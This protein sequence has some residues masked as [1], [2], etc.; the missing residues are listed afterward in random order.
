MRENSHSI[1]RFSYAFTNKILREAFLGKLK[2]CVGECLDKY[3]EEEIAIYDY[4]NGVIA[5]LEGDYCYF[6]EL[7][8][9]LDVGGHYLLYNLLLIRKINS[10]KSF[11]HSLEILRN[12]DVLINEFSDQ[13][14]ES[15]VVIEFQIL[16]GTT[17]FNLKKMKEAIGHYHIAEQLAIKDDFSERLGRVY[18]N[19]SVLYENVENYF[20]YE[21]TIEK[22][23]NLIDGISHPDLI[24]QYTKLISFKKFQIAQYDEG[25]KLLFSTIRSL[26][27]IGGRWSNDLVNLRRYLAYIQLRVGDFDC[28]EKNLFAISEILRIRKHSLWKNDYQLLKLEYY[29]KTFQIEKSKKIFLEL[30]L[31]DLG[32]ATIYFYQFKLKYFILSGEWPVLADFERERFLISELKE[33]GSRSVPEEDGILEDLLM[34]DLVAGKKIDNSILDDLFIKNEKYTRRFNIL[35]IKYIILVQSIINRDFDEVKNILQEMY[36]YC[37][38]LGFNY[39]SLIILYLLNEHL[40][41][42]YRKK[43]PTELFKQLLDLQ[44][45]YGD[46]YKVIFKLFPFSFLKMERFDQRF[47]LDFQT[48]EIRRFGAVIFRDNLTNQERKLLF[49]LYQNNNSVITNEV[50]SGELWNEIYNPEIHLPRL[51]QLVVS[52]RKHFLNLRIH[53]VTIENVSGVGYR[54]N[55]IIEDQAYVDQFNNGSSDFLDKKILGNDCDRDKNLNTTMID[56]FNHPFETPI[57]ISEIVKK[58]GLS[59]RTI[60]RKV[61]EMVARGELKPIGA[62]KARYYL[63]VF[64]V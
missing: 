61:K 44:V 49:L 35:K 32:R 16:Y 48:N 62:G 47:T 27:V 43:L 51:Y 59:T 13:S 40:A 42:T 8:S 39:D 57:Y 9:K 36:G 46:S 2:Q 45:K 34:Y 20:M 5:Y 30:E 18:Y 11:S 56:L 23:K 3:S 1:H 17:L 41:F 52:I 24:V 28:F 10:E 33:F 29:L 58:S 31:V 12:M 64:K 50:L 4:A 14:L 38:K 55:R 6:E 54:F 21:R 25:M 19:L 53:P 26:D 37:K 63:K 60:Q 15:G 7:M 22:Y